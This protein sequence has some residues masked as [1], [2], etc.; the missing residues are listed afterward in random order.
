MQTVKSSDGTTIAYDQSGQGPTI[1]LITG[2]LNYSKF[3]VVGDLVP[4]LSEKFTV[5]NYDRRGRGSSGITQPYSI[6]REVEDL[7]ALILQS[8]SSA[9]LYGHSAGAALA[10]FAAEKLGKSILSV[11][12]YEPPM[13][14][15]WREDLTTKLS[16]ALSRGMVRKGHNLELITQ[17]MRYVGMDEP[18]IAETLASEHRQALI[19]MAPTLIHEA[20]LMLA[21]R[22]FLKHGAHNVTQ[23]VL[24]LAGDKSFRT[25]FKVQKAFSQA[26]PHAATR[27]FE[28][29]THSIEA[30]VLAPVLEEF[31]N[32]VGD[33]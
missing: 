24:L 29:Q 23:P 21:S 19:G 17:F 4:L 22:Q 10:L 28:G 9:H 13:S 6:D 30:A 31:F 15:N 27:I 16:I 32:S 26:L 2:A 14:H 18:S 11:A 5:I 33:N 25:V 12:A 8:G 3:G 1:I 7:H 20:S